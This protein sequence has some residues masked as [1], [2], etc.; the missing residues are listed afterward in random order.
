MAVTG[1]S[2][3]RWADRSVTRYNCHYE[4]RPVE[5]FDGQFDVVGSPFHALFALLDRRQFDLLR[6]DPVVGVAFREERSV[7]DCIQGWEL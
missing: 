4:D 3:T 5:S 7:R 2:A 1:R 6:D